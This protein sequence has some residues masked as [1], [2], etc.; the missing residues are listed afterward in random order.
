MLIVKVLRQQHIGDND[1]FLLDIENTGYDVRV[2]TGS[3]KM[4]CL[5]RLMKK[6]GHNMYYTSRCMFQLKLQGFQHIDALDPS[7]GMLEKAKSKNV[8][9]RYICDFFTEK[10]L[11]IPEGK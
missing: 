7:E 10:Q 11:D 8:Y 3:S 6:Q 1:D 2:D 9:D 4:M 5:P